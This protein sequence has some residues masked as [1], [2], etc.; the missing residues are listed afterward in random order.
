MGKVHLSN[1][2]HVFAYIMYRINTSILLKILI[3]DG[4]HG[5]PKDRHFVKTPYKAK[6]TK[7]PNFTL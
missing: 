7:N 2:I 3:M 1:K 6:A 4:G 5:I